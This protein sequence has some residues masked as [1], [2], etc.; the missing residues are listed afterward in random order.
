MKDLTERLFEEHGEKIKAALRPIVEE[1]LREVAEE[2]YYTT[3]CEAD[4]CLP[5]G[6]PCEGWTG[7][8]WEKA[9]YGHKNRIYICNTSSQYPEVRFRL[10]DIQDRGEK[11]VGKMVKAWRDDEKAFSIGYCFEFYDGRYTVSYMYNGGY[12]T[13][14][15]DHARYYCQSWEV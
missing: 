4:P 14:E 15:F 8:K 11:M 12:A 13:S 7:S 10:S 2:E 1:A 5:N 6:T 3:E 9:Y